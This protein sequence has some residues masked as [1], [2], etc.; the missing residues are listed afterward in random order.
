[1]DVLDGEVGG[2]EDATALALMEL[3]VDD[4]LGLGD[5]GMGADL[6][7]FRGASAVEA[8]GDVAEPDVDAVGVDGRAGVADGGD[9][10][11]PVG[12]GAGPRGLDQRAMAL[13]ILRA[14]ASSF[15][16]SMRSST[17]WVM[18]SPSA[19][20]WRASEVQTW[21]RAMA[22]SALPAPTAAP[23]APEASSRTVSLVEV[24][25]STEMRLKLT[26]MDARR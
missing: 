2:P 22:N 12:I 20:I 10:A 16:P 15:A 18:P 17:T 6:I 14:S 5:V 8:D 26:S 4:E 11:S 19:T 7:E 21:V 1:M 24:S 13:A 25:P 23:L 9:E 3:D